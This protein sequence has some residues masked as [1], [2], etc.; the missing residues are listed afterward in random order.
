MLGFVSASGEPVGGVILRPATGRI[1]IVDVADNF[2]LVS[3]GVCAA[4]GGGVASPGFWFRR[5]RIFKVAVALLAA[6]TG[7]TVASSVGS[8]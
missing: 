1:F 4:A 3:A 5:G 2:A 7:I 6:D 8:A